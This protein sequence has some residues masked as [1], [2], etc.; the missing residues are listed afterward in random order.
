MKLGKDRRE[1]ILPCHIFTWSDV[2]GR[3]AGKA[4]EIKDPWCFKLFLGCDELFLKA[5][6]SLCHNDEQPTEVTL[7]ELERFV[8]LIYKSQVHSN[9]STLR[10]SMYAHNQALDEQLP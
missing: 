2:T 1:S 5:L 8:C 7:S 6:S 10:W 4:K 9:D 3:F